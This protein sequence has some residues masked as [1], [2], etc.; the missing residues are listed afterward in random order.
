MDNPILHMEFAD[1]TTAVRRLVS[2]FTAENNRTYAA[3]FPV[4]ETGDPL[5]GAAFELVRAT[6]CTAENGDP[7]YSIDA[8]RSDMELEVARA[9]FLANISEEDLMA[10]TAALS[11]PQSGG[12]ELPP[13]P[14]LTL[15][16]QDSKVEWQ[17]VDI[18]TVD[19][20]SYAAGMPLPSLD[21]AESGKEYNPVIT[22][23]RAV[24]AV[25]EGVEGFVLEAIEDSAEF[26]KVQAAF[27]IRLI[28]D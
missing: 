21:P 8:I 9:A 4:T 12:D 13:L 10:A 6:P 27:E 15:D 19:G 14:V 28:R 23:F 17:M 16:G 24:E 11:E 7:D 1:G 20:V 26:E 5:P 3:L 25:Q 2:I 18:F 22:I